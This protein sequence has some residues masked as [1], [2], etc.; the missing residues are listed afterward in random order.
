MN[1]SLRSTPHTQQ[2]RPQHTPNTKRRLHRPQR[3]LVVVGARQNHRRR[4][5]KPERGNEI[6]PEEGELQPQQT[7]A[8]QN[9]AKAVD[10]LLPERTAACFAFGGAWRCGNRHQKQGNERHH[11]GHQVNEEHA[12]N[13]DE[14][15]QR[16]RQRGRKNLRNTFGERHHPAGAR[17]MLF[18]DHSRNRRRIRR[19]LERLK[20]PRNKAPHVQ[21][22]DFQMPRDI[23]QPNRRRDHRRRQIAQRHHHLAVPAVHQRPGCGAKQNLWRK[24]EKPHQRQRRRLARG[25]PCPNRQGKR[26]HGCSHQ[27]NHLPYP[28]NEKCS[29]T[30]LL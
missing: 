5:H 18:F 26:G 17:I 13:T 16:R 23:E 7:G 22:P 27:R 10:R 14:R 11:K 12:A 29:Q 20:R 1:A 9:V 8:R 24:R 4:K 30:R 28:D 2:H 3:Q 15:Q 19:P 21:V 25:L 6:R